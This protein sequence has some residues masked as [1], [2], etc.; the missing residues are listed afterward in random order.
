[1]LGFFNNNKARLSSLAAEGPPLDLVGIS[2]DWGISN[3]NVHLRLF[4]QVLSSVGAWHTREMG[5]ILLLLSKDFSRVGV[6]RTVWLL[7]NHAVWSWKD[8]RF[9]DLC[10]ASATPNDFYEIPV[11]LKRLPWQRLHNCFC[12]WFWSTARV[13]VK[14]SELSNSY[15]HHCIWV[16]YSLWSNYSHPL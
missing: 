4:Q 14:T 3:I 12:C 5:V 9:S 7:V 15:I 8:D 11:F 2:P 10:H 16:F 6:G 1:M 13:Q